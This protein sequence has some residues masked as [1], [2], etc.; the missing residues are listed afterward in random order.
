[1]SQIDTEV[2]GRI[3]YAAK[4]LQQAVRAAAERQL[5]PVGLTMPQYAV[6]SA[7][8][9]RPGLSN[10]ELARRCFVTRQTMNEVLAG[11]QRAGLVTRAADP[12]DG[13]VQR[14]ELTAAARRLA[15]RGDRALGEV[16]EQMT[17]GLSESQRQQLLDL[18]L[19][20]TES[21]EAATWTQRKR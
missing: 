19:T 20:C 1:M 21:L 16:E 3:G 11:L 5:R 9:D 17:V 8:T 13:R 2:E 7:L 6:L 15:E 10:S 14:I 4:R 18:M 12:H